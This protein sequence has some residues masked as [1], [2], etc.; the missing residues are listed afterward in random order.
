EKGARLPVHPGTAA[1]L[2]STD[3]S[4]YT[5]FSDQIWTVWLIGGALC[6]VVA[7]FVTRMRA[8]GEDAMLT[9]LDRLRTITQRAK[10]KPAPEELDCLS[11]DLSDIAVELATLGYQHKGEQAEFSAVQLA[12]DNARFVVETARSARKVRESAPEP[13]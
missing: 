4:W 8:S 5:L 11:S 7:A 9:L 1:Y 3:T 6:S 2:D 12:F 13:V 10:A